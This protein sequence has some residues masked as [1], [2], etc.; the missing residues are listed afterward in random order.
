MNIAPVLESGEILLNTELDA[1]PANVW[2]A[3]TEPE[4]LAQWLGPN[5]MKPEEGHR[6]AIDLTEAGLGHV[7]AEVTEAEPG[8]RL[9][10]RWQNEAEAEE[11]A[12]LDTALTF[13]LTETIS[14]GTLL[15]L[16]HVGMPLSLKAPLMQLARKT[17]RPVTCR[18]RRQTWNMKWA[19]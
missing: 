3:L 7:A 2:R 10:L 9:S 14:G 4:L 18:T 1:P 11:G 6:F 19:A 13:I 16:V 8:K 12:S 15:R 17:A 5:G